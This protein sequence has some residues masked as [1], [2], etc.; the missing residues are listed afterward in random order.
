MHATLTVHN[1]DVTPAEPQ[2]KVLDRTPMNN[3]ALLRYKVGNVK[4]IVNVVKISQ[5]AV[6]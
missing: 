6:F 2:I 5:K 4:F 3:A 1:C